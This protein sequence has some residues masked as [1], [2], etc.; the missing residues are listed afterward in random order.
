MPERL[1]FIIDLPLFSE[2]KSLKLKFIKQ[3]P[4]TLLFNQK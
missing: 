1:L 2:S 4:L 3:A